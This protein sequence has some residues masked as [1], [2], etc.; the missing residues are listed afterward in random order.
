MS[1]Q[2]KIFEFAPKDPQEVAARDPLQGDLVKL[3]FGPQHPS[4]H[5]VLRLIITIDGERVVAC[6]PVVGYLHRGKE[7]SAEYLGYQRFI[8]HT[9]RLDYLQPLLNNIAY[10]LAVEKL[11][12]LTLPPR[13]QA[14]RVIQSELSR[15]SAHLIYLGTTAIDLG[16]LSIFFHTFKERERIYDIFDYVHG[17]RMNMSGVRFGGVQNDYDEKAIGMVREFCDDFEEK[18]DEYETLLTDN[19]IWHSRNAGL[20]KLTAAEAIEL[21]LTGPNLRARGVDFDIRKAHPY[22]GYENYEFEVPI[23]KEGDAYDCY[24]V[25]MEEMRQSIRIVRQAIDKLP[26]GDIYV[27]DRRYVLPPKTRALDSM[28]ELIHQFKVVTEMKVPAGEVYH[29]VESSS[30]ELGFY[31]KSHGGIAPHRL[32][33]RSPSFVNIHAIPKLAIGRMISDLVAVIG[34]LHFVMGESDR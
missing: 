31:I 28:E 12:G 22:L 18:V 10:C 4:T 20:A 21:G 6:E 2:T 8:P 14:I 30:G 33:I 32:W 16:A 24:L 23:G 29:A 26:S 13:G 9:D 27:E 7:K 15:I 3:N 19:P 17:H 34:S 25:R 1:L 11:M 5:G